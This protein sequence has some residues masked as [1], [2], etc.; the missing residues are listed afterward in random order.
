MVDLEEHLG[1]TLSTYVVPTP[2][3]PSP[4]A[5]NL[6]PINNKMD[7][8]EKALCLVQG[9]DHQSYQIQDLCYFP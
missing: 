2:A 3:V 4:S 8:L 9:A 6:D 5:A 7:V 1:A